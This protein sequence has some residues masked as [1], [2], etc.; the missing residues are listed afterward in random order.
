MDDE[1]TSETK[2]AVANALA[3][4][5]TNPKEF[6]ASFVNMHE[7]LQVFDMLYE[8]RMLPR[9][10]AV[11]AALVLGVI[12]EPG[13]FIDLRKSSDNMIDFH[14]EDVFRYI[15]ENLKQED[16]I[17]KFISYILFEFYSMIKHYREPGGR[18]LP[19]RPSLYGDVIY[20]LTKF[21]NPLLNVYRPLVDWSSR[22]AKT[23]LEMV[24]TRS[25]SERHREP[26]LLK[27][28]DFYDDLYA[29]ANFE[30]KASNV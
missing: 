22:S 8:R 17:Q 27:M 16:L 12:Q 13:C 28:S 26:L 10:D 6:F 2:R 14:H 7:A 29:E 5:W 11:V 23:V 19:V 21:V 15:V 18:N 25:L 3:S 9:N 20:T 24:Q 4:I 1:H 30:E